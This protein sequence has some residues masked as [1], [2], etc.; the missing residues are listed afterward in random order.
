MVPTLD[1]KYPYLQLLSGAVVR[2]RSSLSF[3]RILHAFRKEGG[4]ALFSLVE[5]T[6]CRQQGWSS[7]A[8]VS[9]PSGTTTSAIFRRNGVHLEKLALARPDFW[10]EM[11]WLVTRAT[12]SPLYSTYLLAINYTLLLNTRM[13]H[14]LLVSEPN[15]LESFGSANLASLEPCQPSNR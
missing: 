15:R 14:K 2:T 1:V 9:Y 3:P 5:T 10:K 12:Q 8:N 6:M 13:L 11:A 7:S 4:A